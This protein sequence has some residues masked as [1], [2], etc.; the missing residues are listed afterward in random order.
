MRL[1]KPELREI[2]KEEVQLLLKE[3]EESLD[4]ILSVIGIISTV[5]EELYSELEKNDSID[6]IELQKEEDVMKTLSSL[7]FV[8]KKLASA[9]E[10]E[11]KRQSEEEPDEE[12]EGEE[13]DTELSDEE[14]AMGLE[15]TIRYHI[16][17]ELKKEIGLNKNNILDEGVSDFLARQ[18][19]AKA[20]AK[21]F[22][23]YH[24]VLQ[25][26]LS[27]VNFLKEDRKL[28]THLVQLVKNFEGT[29]KTLE[30][31][32]KTTVSPK[33]AKGMKIAGDF[34]GKTAKGGLSSFFKGLGGFKL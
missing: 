11:E 17:E 10:E 26:A 18:V 28:N 23:K 31:K 2:V 27:E 6:I 9:Y 13:S 21:I 24:N 14:L 20:A 25:T 4:K 12:G 33:V 15:E 7:E 19:E 22:K 8:M 29:Q 32:A 16:R 34:L 30:T 3:E 1:I 5:Y